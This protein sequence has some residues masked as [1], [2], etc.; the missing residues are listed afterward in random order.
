MAANL[1]ERDVVRRRTFLT[2]HNVESDAV[3]FIE[4]L[5]AGPIDTRKV[6]KY[7]RSVFL[8]NEPVTFFLVEPFDCAFCQDKLLFKKISEWTHAVTR[9]EYWLYLR[10]ETSFSLPRM[11]G[12]GYFRMILTE[13]HLKSTLIAS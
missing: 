12:L 9:Q 10:K 5:K 2:I 1:N 3:T 11:R 8:F 6:D 7:V 13:M 4:C